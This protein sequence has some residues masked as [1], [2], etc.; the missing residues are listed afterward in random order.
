M[1]KLSA[2]SVV[3]L[4]SV[5]SFACPVCEKRQP[6]VLRGITHGGGPDGNM[7]YIIIWAMVVIVLVT[8]YYSVKYLLFPKESNANHIKRLVI[9]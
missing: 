3:M 5:V 2:I 6:K 1:K 8:L 7:D 9:D 4:L